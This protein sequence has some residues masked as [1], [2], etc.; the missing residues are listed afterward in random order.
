VIEPDPVLADRLA[1]KL[2]RF[3]RAYAAIR[4]F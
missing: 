2:A 4:D 1:P 3:R